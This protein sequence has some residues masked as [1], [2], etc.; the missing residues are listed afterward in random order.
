MEGEAGARECGEG[1]AGEEKR[2]K[3]GVCVS[4]FSPWKEE[5]CEGTHTLL[6]LLR[7][8]RVVGG[9]GHGDVVHGRHRWRVCVCEWGALSV[10]LHQHMKWTKEEKK[11]GNEMKGQCKP[12]MYGVS[13]CPRMP[14]RGKEARNITRKETHRALWNIESMPHPS[15]VLPPPDM[16]PPDM[17]KAWFIFAFVGTTGARASRSSVLGGAFCACEAD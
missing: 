17:E 10:A 4:A 5:G 2:P 6:L 13:P 1:E 3:A 16:P 12:H 11:L 7:L 8:L 14:V 15:F 9:P